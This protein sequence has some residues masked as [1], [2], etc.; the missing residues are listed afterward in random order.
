RHPDES[1]K[2]RAADLDGLERAGVEAQCGWTRS[3][4]QESERLGKFVLALRNRLGLFLLLWRA[5]KRLDDLRPVDWA[6]VAL[7]GGGV[8]HGVAEFV[9]VGP[10]PSNIECRDLGRV[11]AR[12][13][14][15]PANVIEGRFDDPVIDECVELVGVRGNPA[16]R[17]V[18]SALS[19][20]ER[21]ELLAD[22]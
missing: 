16:T 7:A 10:F 19:L 18:G 6:N 12:V 4:G 2:T 20:T 5:W 15:E 1:A 22:Q 17:S 14:D 3:H 11:L 21:A 13:C 8:A 9:G